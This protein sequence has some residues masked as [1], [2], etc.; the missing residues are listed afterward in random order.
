MATIF[1]QTGAGFWG[2]LGNGSYKLIDVPLPRRRYIFT[3]MCISLHLERFLLQC[4]ESVVGSQCTPMLITSTLLIRQ[5]TKRCLWHQIK[6][7]G[8]SLCLFLFSKK[9]I[10][11][12]QFIGWTFLALLFLG[13]SWISGYKA[14]NSCL[15]NR[16]VSEI[17]LIHW[18]SF[19][20]SELFH[21]GTG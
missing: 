18:K 3:S 21:W 11:M 2:K 7:R 16:N 5:K 13:L 9:N 1:L 14:K 6:G 20:V 19:A 10:L 17:S 4:S 15:H 8:G 12:W